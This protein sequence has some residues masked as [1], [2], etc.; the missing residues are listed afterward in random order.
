MTSASAGRNLWRYIPLKAFAPSYERMVQPS[1]KPSV[2]VSTI[3]S[4]SPET[5]TPYWPHGWKQSAS[6]LPYRRQKTAPKTLRKTSPHA[7]SLA[8]CPN[9]EMLALVCSVQNTWR[10]TRLE[11]TSVANAARSSTCLC[12][13]PIY[14]GRQVFGRTSRGHTGGMSHRISPPSF[15]GACLDFYCEK[16]SAVHFPRRP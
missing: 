10:R 2:A 9:A 7:T 1:L 13:H 6:F 12:C 5:A 3:I 15:C 14:S 4:T 8:F 11:E 16:D